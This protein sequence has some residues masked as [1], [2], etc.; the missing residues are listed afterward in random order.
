M[1]DPH[2]T[3]RVRKGRGIDVQPA[4]VLVVEPGQAGLAGVPEADFHQLAR[5]RRSG[6]LPMAELGERAE[7]ELASALRP[8]LARWR[9]LH[10]DPSQS[11][12]SEFETESEPAN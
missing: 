2:R 3:F 9:T 10:H 1:R 11:V 5:I 6:R 4:E 7:R 12:E 8:M